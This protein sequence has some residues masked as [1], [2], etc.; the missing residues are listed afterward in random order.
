VTRTEEARVAPRS[1]RSWLMKGVR[2]ERQAHLA[3]H[4]SP[5]Q[6]EKTHHW[7]QVM[8]L[9]GVDYFSTLGYQPGIAALAAGAISPIATVV[10]VALTLLGALPVYR[11]VAWESPNGEGSLAMLERL[12]SFWKGKIFVLVLLGF[13]AT[14]FIIT[15][16]LSAADATAHLVENPHLEPFLSGHQVAVTLFLLALLG[17]VF[18]RGFKEALASR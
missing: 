9:T 17:A 5:Q 11:R 15:M 12:L 13:A 10:L 8:C 4:P 7:W 6:T 2:E 14:D 3:P 16:T 1:L 18:L